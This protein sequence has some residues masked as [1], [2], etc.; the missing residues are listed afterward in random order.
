M[1]HWLSTSSKERERERKKTA[2]SFLFGAGAT[3][4]DLQPYMVCVW[5]ARWMDQLVSFERADRRAFIRE[6]C[7]KSVQFEEMVASTALFK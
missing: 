4:A 6:R 1:T 5:L 7:V 3:P 2:N